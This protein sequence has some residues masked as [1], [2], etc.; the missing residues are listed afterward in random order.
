MLEGPRGFVMIKG[1]N[2]S[3]AVIKELLR[4]G[5]A[6]RNGVVKVSQAF[7]T[8]YRRLGGRAVV[9]SYLRGSDACKTEDN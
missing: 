3:Q 2:E 4:L 8:R 7:H 9:M 5:I 6:S 1:V